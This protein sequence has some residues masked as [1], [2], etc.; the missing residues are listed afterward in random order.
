M[1]KPSKVVIAFA[2]LVAVLVFSATVSGYGML[3]Q[4]GWLIWLTAILLI[5]GLLSFRE[6]GIAQFVLNAA[7]VVSIGIAVMLVGD[8]IRRAYCFNRCRACEPIM[9]RL[10]A[11]RSSQG[12]FPT[13]L[14]SSELP[15]GFTIQQR[16]FTGY[17]LDVGG[18]NQTD[19]T[20]YL[21]TNSFVCVV[22]VTKMLPISFTRFY[23]YVRNDSDRHWRYEQIT[24]TLGIIR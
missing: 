19:A 14:P 7:V 8:S 10:S 12:A 13:N 2:L 20:L 22:P 16:P 24:W 18:V 23:A 3:V 9:E 17:D 15:Q 11:L 21:G 6:S 5:V 4:Y 1:G